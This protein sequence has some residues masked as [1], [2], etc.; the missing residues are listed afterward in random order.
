MEEQ[1]TQSTQEEAL[2]AL[3]LETL[4]KD[5]SPNKYRLIRKLIEASHEQLEEKP[6]PLREPVDDI[7]RESAA[8]L[9]KTKISRSSDTEPAKQAINR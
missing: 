9:R 4:V 2:A 1:K 5:V 8:R 3:Y 7:L 6:D